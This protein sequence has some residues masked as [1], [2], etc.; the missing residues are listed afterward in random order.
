MGRGVFAEGRLSTVDSLRTSQTPVS[1]NDRTLEL[2]FVGNIIDYLYP[3]TPRLVDSARVPN[4]AI[5]A[6]EVLDDDTR[7]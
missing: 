2:E 5:V 7:Y 4:A 1:L 3:W 6:G